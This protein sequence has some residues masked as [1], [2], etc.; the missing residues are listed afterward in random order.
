MGTITATDLARNTREVLD[1]VASRRET[2][3]VERNHI[4]IA[5]IVPPEPAMTAA[6]ALASWR[7]MLTPAQAIA[8]LKDSRDHF[9]E[10]VRDPWA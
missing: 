10:A 4:P 5:R 3:I 8:W 1:A 6:E 9:D 7:P 2:I